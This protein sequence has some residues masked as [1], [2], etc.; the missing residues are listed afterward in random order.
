[1]DVNGIFMAQLR[2]KERII[3]D[4][5]ICSMD[6]FYMNQAKFK[7]FP[8]QNIITFAYLMNADMWKR[9]ID[10]MKMDR[11]PQKVIKKINGLFDTVRAKL[12]KIDLGK[13]TKV[14]EII[15]TMARKI[16]SDFRVSIRQRSV[17]DALFKNMKLEMLASMKELHADYLEVLNE[18]SIFLFTRLKNL[19]RVSVIQ[20]YLN[21][22]SKGHDLHVICY[23]D[24][25]HGLLQKLS[26]AL[27]EK[28]NVEWDVNNINASMILADEIIRV[29]KY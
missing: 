28:I 2:N 3:F 22:C 20:N 13:E 21:A 14:G 26:A 10:K 16:E 23:Q 29:H 15:R 19:Y 6:L 11:N 17:Y 18:R 8:C 9:V 7:D 24:E 27:A 12:I 25:E 5:A 1:M 4:V